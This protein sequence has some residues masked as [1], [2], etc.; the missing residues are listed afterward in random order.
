MKKCIIIMMFLIIPINKGVAQNFTVFVQSNR[1]KIKCENCIKNYFFFGQYYIDKKNNNII[2]LKTLESGINTIIPDKN[3]S[4]LIVLDI[5]N[6]IYQNIKTKDI[7]D[8]NYKSNIGKLVEMVKLTKRIRPKAKIVLYGMP[9]S[10]NYNFQNKSF[11]D[12]NKLKPLLQVVDYLSPALYLMYS[13]RQ[14]S[15]NFFKNYIKDNL[16]MT[17]DMAAKVN[18]P[19]IPFIWYKVHPYNKLFGGNEISDS[20]YNLYLNELQKYEFKGK[21][22]AGVIYWEPAKETI[23]INHK[24]EKSI[25]ILN[26]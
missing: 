15:D 1:Y 6:E 24:L 17:F 20:L 18:K 8:I 23:N 16:D 25:K 13:D 21:K 10:F 4:D 2:D 11:N 12:F 26:K 19:V 5:E 3:N 7:S 22:I 14:K 9:Y